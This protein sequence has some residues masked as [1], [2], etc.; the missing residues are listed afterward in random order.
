M[1]GMRLSPTAV[2]ANRLNAGLFNTAAAALESPALL[3]C[4]SLV[5]WLMASTNLSVL[6][7]ARLMTNPGIT[8]EA[9]ICHMNVSAT[10]DATANLMRSTRAIHLQQ[11]KPGHPCPPNLAFTWVSLSKP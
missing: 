10:A 5:R 2:G 11:S 9:A 8:T 6:D 4:V 1:S 3:G 7:T